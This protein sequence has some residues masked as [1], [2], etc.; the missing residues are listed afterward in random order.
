MRPAR[1]V[2]RRRAAGQSGLFCS[3]MRIVERGLGLIGGS[4]H[5]FIAVAV[6]GTGAPVA[7]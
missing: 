1:A 3:T 7:P 2:A 6:A 5:G 4:S